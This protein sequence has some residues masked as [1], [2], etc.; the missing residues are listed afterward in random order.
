LA[1][2]SSEDGPGFGLR[3]AVYTYDGVTIPYRNST[4][5]QAFFTTKGKWAHSFLVDY[6]QIRPG[7]RLEFEARYDREDRANYFGSLDDSQINTYSRNEQT[8]RQQDPYLSVR[9]IRD[10]FKPWRLQLGLRAGKTFIDPH[11]SSGTIL[12]GLAPLGDTGGGLAQFNA[13]LRYDTRDNYNNATQGYLTEVRVEHGLGGGT[14]F[15]GGTFD[16][17]HRYFSQP[18]HGLV[19]AHRASATY[20]YGDVPFFEQPKLGSSKTLRGLSADR[21]RGEARILFNT[22]LR[23]LGLSLSR[24]HKVYGGLNLFGDVGQIYDRSDAPSLTQWNV[25]VGIGA[26]LYWYSTVVRADYGRSNGDSAIYMR[27]AQIF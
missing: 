20:T 15:N 24:K 19:F 22:E 27:F 11:E 26:R 18:L 13:A 12:Q 25:G 14:S 10:L 3:L 8:F 4:S 23:W 9:W 2:F 1:G 5:I 17:Q 16:F 6:P 21:F 7:H